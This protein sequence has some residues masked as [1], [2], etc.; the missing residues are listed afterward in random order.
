MS[1]DDVR[2]YYWPI[3]ADKMKNG[4]ASGKRISMTK[5]EYYEDCERKG[6]KPKDI[7]RT[8]ADG[9]TVVGKMFGMDVVVENH[10]RRTKISED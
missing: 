2:L 8:K 10:A 4:Q 9:E 5:L 3:F 1:N 7:T 6:V